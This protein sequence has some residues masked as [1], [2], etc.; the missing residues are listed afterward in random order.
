MSNSP[1][2]SLSSQDPHENT[3]L[4]I[5]EHPYFRAWYLSLGKETRAVFDLLYLTD[6]T[7]QLI[8]F[9]RQVPEGEWWGSLFLRVIS[10]SI[11]DSATSSTLTDNALLTV[12]VDMEHFGRRTQSRVG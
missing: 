8:S 4:K 3:R 1:F 10:G 5:Q 2:P 6:V 9:A 7:P 11:P 12:I